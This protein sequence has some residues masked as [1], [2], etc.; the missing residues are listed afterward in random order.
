MNYGYSSVWR[1]GGLFFYTD[2]L[3]DLRQ[4]GFIIKPLLLHKAHEACFPD[5]VRL[6]VSIM[7]QPYP[8]LD[9]LWQ[10]Q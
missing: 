7:H 2:L 8:T 5:K 4:L 9:W 10:G 1:S 6:I 3:I